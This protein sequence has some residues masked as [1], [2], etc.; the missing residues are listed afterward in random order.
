[1][2][3]KTSDGQPTAL[4]RLL[5]ADGGF[6]YGEYALKPDAGGALKAIDVFTYSNGEWMTES[7]RREWLF[8]LA[9]SGRSNLARLA[10]VESDLTQYQPQLQAINKLQDSGQHRGAL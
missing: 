5:A 9:H 1:H 10:G 2:A 4:F 6:S 7:L 8:N 3:R